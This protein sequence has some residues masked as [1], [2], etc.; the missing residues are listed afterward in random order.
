MSARVLTSSLRKLNSQS[1]CCRFG[2]NN[3]TKLLFATI[4]Y[5]CLVFFFFFFC[6]HISVESYINL[7]PTRKVSKGLQ[8]GFEIVGPSAPIIFVQFLKSRNIV[9]QLFGDM[10]EFF[11]FPLSFFFVIGRLVS[12]FQ[13]VRLLRPT[14]SCSTNSN[15]RFY[16]IEYLGRHT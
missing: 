16:F 13:Y 10:I 15:L 9:C 6:G 11:N 2:P 5:I 14:K 4:F 3:P 12:G 8:G 1:H 7:T